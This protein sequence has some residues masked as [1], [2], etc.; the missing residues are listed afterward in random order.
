[1]NKDTEIDDV[2]KAFA[3]ITIPMMQEE[4]M[5]IIQ[6]ALKMAEDI[7]GLPMLMQ[8]QQG[9]ATDT[10]GGMQILTNNSNTPMRTIAKLFDDMI[11]TPHL[12]RYYEW[13]L[14]YG[15]DDNEKGDFQ[16]TARG[17]SAL[18]ERDAQHQAILAM[19]PLVKDPAYGIDPKKWIKEALKAQR[20]LPEVFQYTE[21]EMKQME[22]AMKANPP[23]DPKLEVARIGAQARIETAKIAAEVQKER[24]AKDTDRDTVYVQAEMQRAQA[25]INAADKKLQQE[26]QITLAKFAEERN[27]SLEAAKV[28][29]SKIAM[30]LQTQKEL[31]GLDAHGPQ[32]SKP[33]TEPP[34]RAYDGQAYQE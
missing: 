18:F 2:R 26:L 33:P 34:G 11:T 6:F 24:I 21:E 13:L 8:G 28:E 29:L 10:V 30:Q 25:A 14:Q 31:A 1:M 5:A 3:A 27:L 16:I 23:A 22:E 9:S 15:P 19:A 32:V 4:L 17:S 7:T 20:L 12:N